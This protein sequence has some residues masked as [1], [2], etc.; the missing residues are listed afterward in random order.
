[1]FLRFG[2]LASLYM[3]LV[4]C[5]KRAFLSNATAVPAAIAG[6]DATAEASHADAIRFN[7]Q[8]MELKAKINALC[9]APY[10]E[11][12]NYYV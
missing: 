9:G 7:K 1:M 4:L 3:D 10:D 11:V 12:K 5:N 8:R 6:N 2:G